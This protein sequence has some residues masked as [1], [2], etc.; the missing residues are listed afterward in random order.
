MEWASREQ[1]VKNYAE[2]INIRA[3]R[4]ALGARL[5]RRHVRGLALQHARLFA[6][7]IGRSDAEIS[8]FY[9]AIEAHQNVLRRHVAVHDIDRLTRF[10]FTLVRVVQTLR[11]F[12]DDVS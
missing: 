12:G 10:V 9:G 8:Y 4:H 1:L 7:Q 11:D 6:E 2:R 3:P 5:L